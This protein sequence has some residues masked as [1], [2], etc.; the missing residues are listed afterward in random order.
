MVASLLTDPE[1]ALSSK[2]YLVSRRLRRATEKALALKGHEI[3]KRPPLRPFGRRDLVALQSVGW[4]LVSSFQETVWNDFMIA[5]EQA[6]RVKKPKDDPNL[7]VSEAVMLVKSAASH[8]Y[9]LML[10]RG[11]NA[12]PHVSTRTWRRSMHISPRPPFLPSGSSD[13]WFSMKPP[14]SR[15]DLR[16][17]SLV[18]VS[19]PV[20]FETVILVAVAP[21]K[22]H[23]QGTVT[24]IGIANTHMLDERISNPESVRRFLAAYAP[25]GLVVCFAAMVRADDLIVNNPAFVRSAAER[26]LDNRVYLDWS[27]LPRFRSATGGWK[28]GVFVAEKNTLF[29]SHVSSAAEGREFTVR[30]PSAFFEVKFSFNSLVFVDMQNTAEYRKRIPY[31]FAMWADETSKEE[32][33][34]LFMVQKEE[35]TKLAKGKIDEDGEVL[36]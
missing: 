35:Y 16:A 20:V 15:S 32:L 3:L 5:L 26:S 12:T 30:L 31:D 8:G 28:M 23:F 33:E 17:P 4:K 24:G 27:G 19:P 13:Y 21:T 18:A 2:I 11:E 7:V 29:G 10:F 34:R 25:Q 36:F 14:P 1:A 6:L 22:P 9:R